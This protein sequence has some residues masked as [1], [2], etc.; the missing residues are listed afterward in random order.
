MVAN[1]EETKRKKARARAR[2]RGG[3][4][5]DQKIY[6]LLLRLVVVLVLAPIGWIKVDRNR[7]KDHGIELISF[8]L[9]LLLV[10]RESF[11]SGCWFVCSSSQSPSSLLLVALVCKI[12]VY[13]RF[14]GSDHAR[15]GAREGCIIDGKGGSENNIH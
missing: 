5:D 6:L 10:V 3:S 7:R 1:K 11:F 13:R 12:R 8:D 14:R 15:M 4:D 2:K 9:L